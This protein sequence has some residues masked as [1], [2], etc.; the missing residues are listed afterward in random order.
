[1]K[2]LAVAPQPFFAPRGTPLS[3]YYRTKVMAEQGHTIDLLTY[4]EGDDIDLPN[5]RQRRIPRLRWLEPV[6]VGPSVGKLVLDHLM[7]LWTLGLLLRHRYDLV[8]AHEEAIFWCRPLKPLF[9]FRLIYDMHSSLPQQ[10]DNFQTGQHRLVHRVFSYLEHTGLSGS[11]AIVT[12]C[13]D[14]AAQVHNHNG[15]AQ[16]HVLIENS[17]F[18]RVNLAK[19]AAS[20]KDGHNHQASDAMTALP[21]D[22]WLT[23][24]RLVFYCGTLE[25]YQGIDL[26]LQAFAQLHETQ[27]DTGLLIIGGSEEQVAR[28]R[29]LAHDL[30]INGE[31]CLTGRLSRELTQQYRDCATL[32]VSPRLRGN[33]TPLKLYEYL[34]SGKP[35]VAT[36]VRSHT[37][38]LTEAECFLADPEPTRLA[39][40]LDDALSDPAQASRR[41]EAAQAL[42]QTHYNR[43]AYEA[44]IKRLL[45]VAC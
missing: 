40:R 22:Q 36:A 18:D 41:A 1:M 30:G 8:H 42:Y 25:A 13:P 27:P 33:N 5:V 32:L 26:L 43:S 44:K 17:I 15:C 35:L 29:Q 23:A 3:V 14:L 45:E 21:S 16:R 28:Y 12:I 37:Q 10:L 2:I 34:A 31:I 38:V 9:R 24:R 11:D 19:P 7:L 39:Q 6:R 4:G 20:A